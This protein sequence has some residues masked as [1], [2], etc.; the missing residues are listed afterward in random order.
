MKNFWSTIGKL[1]AKAAVWAVEHPDQVIAIANAAKVA[2][3]K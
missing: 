2:K 3:R 1:L